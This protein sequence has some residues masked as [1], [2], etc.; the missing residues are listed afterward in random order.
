MWAR[1]IRF[2]SSSFCANLMSSYC[3]SAFCRQE[4]TLA[5]TS[6][7]HPRR[8]ELRQF[9]DVWWHSLLLFTYLITAAC[10]AT[11]QQMI[12]IIIIT[13]TLFILLLLFSLF[14]CIAKAIYVV[15][16]CLNQVTTACNHYFILNVTK[17]IDSIFSTLS[18]LCYLFFNSQDLS[19]PLT[20]FFS[21]HILYMY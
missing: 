2:H 10:S 13:N 15:G 14:C 5:E 8:S 4:Q 21:A 20:H 7:P 12:V 1:V 9:D 6:N 11:A 17:K 19:L 16:G 18:L 3:K